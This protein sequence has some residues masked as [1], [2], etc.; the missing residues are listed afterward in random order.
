M[1][2]FNFSGHGFMDMTAYQSYLEDGLEDY[3]YPRTRVEEALAQ[4]PQI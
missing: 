1:I 3:E 4:V 2:L